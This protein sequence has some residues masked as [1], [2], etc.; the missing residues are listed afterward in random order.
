MSVLP[1]NSPLINKG[2][3]SVFVTLFSFYITPYF[4]VKMIIELIENFVFMAVLNDNWH[5]FVWFVQELRTGNTAMLRP[6]TEY[7]TPVM[8]V[9]FAEFRQCR[10]RWCRPAGNTWGARA[11][12]VPTLDDHKL[13]TNTMAYWLTLAVT[14]NSQ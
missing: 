3:R 12:R 1:E 14:L 10:F 9:V 6:G 5:S 7:P 8:S 11:H 2:E 13:G 4:L